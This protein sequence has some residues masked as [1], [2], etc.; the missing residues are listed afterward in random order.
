MSR[1]YRGD[2]TEAPEVEVS[3]FDET[4]LEVRPVVAI[5]DNGVVVPG[6]EGVLTKIARCCTPV[7]PDDIIGMVTRYNGISVHRRDCP[8]MRN[9][10][11]GAVRDHGGV[12]FLT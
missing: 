4:L 11:A 10:D 1:C 2:E 9:A 8:N 7:P 3:D 6:A 5:G 12:G